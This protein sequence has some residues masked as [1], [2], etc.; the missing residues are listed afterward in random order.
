MVFGDQEYPEETAIA[1][2]TC[3]ESYKTMKLRSDVVASIR[4]RMWDVDF[5]IPNP[6]HHSFKLS[7]RDFLVPATCIPASSM[8]C[9]KRRAS[10]A[11]MLS[12]FDRYFQIAPCFRTKTR[13]RTDRQPIL[14]VG[15]GN[16]FCH[17]AGCF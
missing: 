7:A 14:S 11:L 3:R 2:W 9:R 8:R 4:K 17:A 5:R 15:H 13:A 6:D 12:G 1:I 10:Q 16:V